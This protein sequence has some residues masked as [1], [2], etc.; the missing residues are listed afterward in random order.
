MRLY[1]SDG[2]FLEDCDLPPAS[3]SWGEVSCNVS[4]ENDETQDFYV[5][6]QSEIEDIT[7]Y[8]IQRED[9]DACGF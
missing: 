1:N 9:E 4:Y 6:I 2:E 3:T 7:R 5:C 8:L